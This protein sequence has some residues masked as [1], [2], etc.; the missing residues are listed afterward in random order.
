M[1]KC[2]EKLCMLYIYGMLEFAIYVQYMFGKSG[3]AEKYSIQNC[4]NSTGNCL[5]YICTECLD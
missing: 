2:N 5:C 1:G 3:F 4:V